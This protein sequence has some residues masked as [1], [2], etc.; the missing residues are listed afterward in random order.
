MSYFESSW[1]F[2]YREGTR[3]VQLK[4]LY[5]CFVKKTENISRIN[6]TWYHKDFYY[7][8]SLG[9]FQNMRYVKVFSQILQITF[10]KAPL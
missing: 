4:V 7:D 2:T 6:L 8:K 1:N 5:I 10:R 3:N 9:D